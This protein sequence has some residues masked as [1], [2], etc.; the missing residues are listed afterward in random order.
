MVDSYRKT[1]QTKFLYVYLIWSGETMTMGPTAFDWRDTYCHFC[2][3]RLWSLKTTTAWDTQDETSLVHL[4]VSGLLRVTHGCGEAGR[5][6][7]T[8]FLRVEFLSQ[9]SFLFVIWGRIN[10]DSAVVCSLF[11]VNRALVRFSEE[12]AELKV[13][14]GLSLDTGLSLGGASTSCGLCWGR[15]AETPADVVR[16]QLQLRLEPEPG[17]LVKMLLS[18]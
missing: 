4:I 13:F 9:A 18:G 2:K 12:T 14:P 6:P 10:C 17:G 8:S 16:E 3:S 7:Q 11:Y 1:K 15:R 5:G